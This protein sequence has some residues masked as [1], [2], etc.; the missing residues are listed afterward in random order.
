MLVLAGV[1][2]N[3]LLAFLGARG[4]P[5]SLPLVI[6][7][8]LAVLGAAALVLLRSGIRATDTPA[9]LLFAFFLISALVVS[10]IN[11]EL[12][13]DM[14]RN[15]AIITIFLMIGARVD[16]R[17]VRRTFAIIASL[18]FAFL[19]LEIVSV[20]SYAA[21]LEPGRYFEQTRGISRFELDEIG[22]F[23]NA[24]GFDDRFSIL[25]IVGHRTSSLFLEQV[26]LA[27]FAIVTTVF[28]VSM[29]PRI[30]WQARTAYALLIILILVTTNSRTALAIV[31]VA[32]LIYVIAPKLPRFIT[33]GLMPAVVLSAWLV[34]AGMPV[35][36]EDTLVGRVG[37]TIR[38]LG[39]VDLLASLG[40]KAL[41]AP[42][43]V[44]SGYT[45][46]IYASS[47]FGLCVLWIFF[48]T[49]AAGSDAVQKRCNM[50]LG[51]YLAVNLLIGATAVFTIKVAALLYL[52]VGFI[53]RESQARAISSRSGRDANEGQSER[54]R[55]LRSRHV[56]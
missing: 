22:L 3:T 9:V 51:I 2:Y 38:T 34:T 43:L 36:T 5:T 26:S 39:D 47:I 54:M 45:Y 27:N 42:S 32:P 12:F 52:L 29:W 30:S 7:A 40:G 50:M 11:G 49:F 23:A 53:Q 35:S 56:T 8:E 1:C 48:A 18:V 17:T 24:I 41:E 31:L 37:L 13:I 19:L 4:L 6:V 14:A 25:D 15:V 55:A 16:E 20:S 46:I 44:D 21:L 33:L 10:L 28:V